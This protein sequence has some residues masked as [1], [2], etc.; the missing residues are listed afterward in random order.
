MTPPIERPLRKGRYEGGECLAVEIVVG[1]GDRVLELG[2]GIGLVS[3]KAAMAEGVERVLTFEA[4]PSLIPVIREIHHLNG[5]A[6]RIEVVNGLVT[7]GEAPETL[8]FYRRGDFWASSLSPDAGAYV[9]QVDVATHDFDAVLADLKPTVVVCDIEGAE[10]D[11]FDGADLAS[12]RF[13]I[14]EIHPKVYGAEG[15]RRIFDNM[16]AKGFGYSPKVSRGGTVVTFER[17][18]PPRVEAIS[19]FVPSPMATPVADSA[20]R[21]PATTAGPRVLIPTCMKNEGPYILEWIAYHRAIGVTD[22]V[23]FSNDCT[24]GTDLLLD[25]LDDLGVIQHL[26]NPALSVNSPHFQPIALT[27]VPH[28][29]AF[30]E[31]DYVISMDVDEFLNIRV[32]DGTISA[33]LDA[34]GDADAISLMESIFACD[35]QEAF[36]DD[37]MI[38]QFTRCMT[39]HP[40]NHRARRGVKT[41]VRRA[42]GLTIKNHRP[43]ETD[44]VSYDEIRWLDGGGRPVPDAFMADVENGMDCRGRYDLAYLNHYPLR[45][46]EGF[47]LKHDRGDVVSANRRVTHRYWRT[48]NHPD[49][50]DTSLHTWLPQIRDGVA[51]LMEDAEIAR[52]HQASV[53]WHRQRIAELRAMPEYLE[54]LEGLKAMSGVTPDDVGEGTE[55]PST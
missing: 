35:G 34:I 26:P 48:R 36:E 17:V 40:G 4:N 44:Q 51:A 2:T 47:L 30:R 6:D 5:V 9:D 33:L 15:V 7:R 27:Y 37:L 52:L 8:P 13:V 24:D 41:L 23:I 53:D 25:R 21:S 1:R 10:L 22:F 18:G 46:M 43:L 28:L 38:Q 42:S 14:M 39:Y 16:S 11:L 20:E 54:F 50:E 45:S 12:A 19:T 32:G 49:V 31:A 3:T 55:V 29:R